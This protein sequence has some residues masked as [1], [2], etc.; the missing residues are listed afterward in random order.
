M[1]TMEKLGGK[2]IG[3]LTCMGLERS[4]KQ[5][6]KTVVCGRK[7]NKECKSKCADSICCENG[8]K[9]SVITSP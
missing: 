9:D 1:P 8:C 2:K 4:E 3:G 6:T 7:K 5:A